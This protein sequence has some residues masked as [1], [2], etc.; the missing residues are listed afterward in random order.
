MTKDEFLDAF[1]HY[2]I[3]YGAETR[4]EQ[5]EVLRFL[6]ENGF[7]LPDYVINFITGHPDRPIG[8][9]IG[10]DHECNY[11]VNTYGGGGSVEACLRKAKLRYAD[12]LEASG[13]GY[14]IS[15]SPDDILG[16]LSE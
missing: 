10:G 5:I 1:R 16:L 6:Q 11:V 12:Y 3:V 8:Y 14:T 13:G 2:G 15:V 7:T 4:E 9:C